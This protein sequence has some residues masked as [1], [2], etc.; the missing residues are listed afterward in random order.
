MAWHN[1]VHFIQ[2]VFFF[3]FLS[4][5]CVLADCKIND[6]S[7]LGHKRCIYLLMHNHNADEYIYI[8]ANGSLFSSL[9]LSVF[10]SRARSMAF[11]K[12]KNSYN[13]ICGK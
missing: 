6:I 10:R 12:L 7:S 4:R 1:G 9:L 8:C 2:R 3:F 13:L 5:L 11:Q